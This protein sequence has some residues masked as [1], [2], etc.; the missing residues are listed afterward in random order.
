MNILISG[1]SG[2]L[3]SAFSRELMTRYRIQNKE[4]QITW[5]TRDSSQA[6]PDDIAM[7]TYDELARTDKS[8]DV[9]LNL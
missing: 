3:G 6:H 9:I 5:L 4:L 1:G 2:F 7:M 8:F